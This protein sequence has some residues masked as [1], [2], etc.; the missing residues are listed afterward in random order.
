[1]PIDYS[2]RNALGKDPV[3]QGRVQI[4]CLQFAGYIQL[5]PAAT[6]AHTSRMK[7]A[8]M[9]NAEPYPMAVKVANVVVTDPAVIEAGTDI[10]DAALQSSVETT[11][12]AKFI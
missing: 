2:Q 11:V 10:T 9:T 3:F 4:A 1:M 8:T 5:E 12:Q 6:A 7:W